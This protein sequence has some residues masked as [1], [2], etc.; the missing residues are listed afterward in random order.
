MNTPRQDKSTSHTGESFD[1]VEVHTNHLSLC[2]CTFPSHLLEK[3]KLWPIPRNIRELR[4]FLGFVGFLRISI[5]NYSK[6][7]TQLTKLLK[8]HPRKSIKPISYNEKLDTSFET[9]R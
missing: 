4:S 1:I 5:R 7:T 9:L 6:L 8:G 3:I 2:D